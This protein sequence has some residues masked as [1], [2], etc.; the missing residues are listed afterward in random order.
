MKTVILADGSSIHTEKWIQGHLINGEK[1]LFL[2]SLSANP[3]RT[4]IF[5]FLKTENIF[6]LK[7]SR[8]KESGNN[9]SYITKLFRVYKIIKKIKPEH[10]STIYLTSYGLI[11]ALLKRNVVL[12][13]FLV[14]SDI[15]V[16]PKKSIIYRLLTKYALKKA[17]LLVCASSSIEEEVNILN[18]RFTAKLITQQYGVDEFVINYPKQQKKIDFISNRAW[19]RNSNI[20]YIIDIF[21]KIDTQPNVIIIGAGGEQED[22][23]MSGICELKNITNLGVLPYS[24]NIDKVSKSRFF[25]SLTTSDGASLSLLEAMALGTIPVVSNIKPNL[26]WIIDGHNGFIVDLNNSD[27]ACNKIQKILSTSEE[28]LYSMAQ[29]NYKIIQEKACLK[30]N[31]KKYINII[32]EVAIAY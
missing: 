25:L 27:K 24:E 18:G 4:A 21:K 26:E 6:H 31:M 2:I 12:S 14:G 28:V 11:G 30:N 17:N 13:H 22:D 9:F 8:V 19:V 1:E 10:I 7:S 5:K 16:T 20:L 3:T 15:M 32:Y 23:I 29:A